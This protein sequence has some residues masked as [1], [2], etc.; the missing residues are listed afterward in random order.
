[1][2]KLYEL[3]GI[4]PQEAHYAKYLGVTISNDLEWSTHVD[5]WGEQR[6]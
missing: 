1:M 2:S 3:C 6:P 4:N 5:R